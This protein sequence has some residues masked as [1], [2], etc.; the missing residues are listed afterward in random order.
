MFEQEHKRKTNKGIATK[1]PETPRK[2]QSCKLFISNFLYL[3]LPKK[4]F[5]FMHGMPNIKVEW[6]EN[7]DLILI[8]I[9]LNLPFYSHIFPKQKILS[10][11]KTIYFNIFRS[12]YVRTTT[13]QTTLMIN[14]MVPSIQKKYAVALSSFRKTKIDRHNN[15]PTLIL[16]HFHFLFRKSVLFTRRQLIN[17]FPQFFTPHQ[18]QK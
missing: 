14:D 4:L 13:H 1:E 17:F 10:A 7:H 3:I 18:T 11:K 2:T 5:F 16:H 6:T 15:L 9:Q 12:T 8:I